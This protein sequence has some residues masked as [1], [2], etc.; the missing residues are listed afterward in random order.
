MYDLRTLRDNMDTIR[1][2]LGSR[3]SD[4]PWDTLRKLVDE[5][6][7]LTGQ[8]E[9]LR[10][11]L[12]KG[13]DNVARLKRDKQPA[14]SAMAAMKAVGER[15]KNLEAGLREVEDALSDLNLRIPNLPHASV[16]VGKDAS[17]NVEVRSGGTA[18]S[19]DPMS[20]DAIVY[21]RQIV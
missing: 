17:G 10:H 6:R 13:S 4:V 2:Q 3:G 20:S 7:A 9:Q 14:D 1:E 11:E 19:D 16:P 21:G 5:R 15:I 18:P 12:K 8:V